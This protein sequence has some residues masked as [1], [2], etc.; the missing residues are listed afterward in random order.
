[1]ILTCHFHYPLLWQ[2]FYVISYPFLFKFYYMCSIHFVYNAFSLDWIIHLN[3]RLKKNFT[4]FVFLWQILVCV[5]PISFHCQILVVNI[6]Q[7]VNQHF[8]STFTCVSCSSPVVSYHIHLYDQLSKL[9][10]HTFNIL[11]CLLYVDLC[12][13]GS[14]WSVFD[15]RD[16]KLFR[17]SI[18]IHSI[19]FLIACRTVP[20]NICRTENLLYNGRLLFIASLRS[21][22]PWKISRQV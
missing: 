19:C 16:L 17:F 4:N 13:I 14:Y 12:R 22:F 11:L 15:N 1:M 2:V 7:P 20:V 18:V 9:Y 3:S 5:Y 21:Y 6:K 8:L 10:L